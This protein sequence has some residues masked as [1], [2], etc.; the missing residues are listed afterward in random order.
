[1][2]ATVNFSPTLKK[3]QLKEINMSKIEKLSTKLTL[4]EG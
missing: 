4:I 3:E 2:V 1:M